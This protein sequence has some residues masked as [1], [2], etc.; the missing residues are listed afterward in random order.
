ML[1]AISVQ[2]P[3]Y[4]GERYLGEALESACTQV[5]PPTEVIVVDDGSTDGTAMIAEGFGGPV[6]CI[7]ASHRGTAAARNTGLA[8][9]RGP[10]LAFLDADD[11]WPAGSL[12]CRLDALMADAHLGM[13]G[14]L[15]EQFISPELPDD[16]RNKYLCP[17][18]P[19]R[20][21]VPGALLMRRG[22]VDLVGGFDESLRM[23]E[24]VDWAVRADAAGVVTGMVEQVVLRRR[25]HGGNSGA[26][27]HAW[28]AD[29]LRVIKQSLDRKRAAAPQATGPDA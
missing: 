28:R 19:S 26:S 12:A 23:A 18:E 16:V 13:A 3:C 6:R 9:M 29:Y 7:R 5:P 15:V 11:V 1:P 2:V 25:I 17:S 24:V 10:L 20:G 4:N 22:V 27:N 8:A 21:R 14:G